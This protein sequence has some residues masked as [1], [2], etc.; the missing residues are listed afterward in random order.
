MV[1]FPARSR[2]APETAGPATIRMYGHGNVLGE[3][4]RIVIIG[5]ATLLL[6]VILSFVLR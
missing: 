2:P 4:R 3:L 5:G 6:V 1:P